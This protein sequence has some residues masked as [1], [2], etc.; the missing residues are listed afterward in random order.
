M[1]GDKI[2]EAEMHFEIPYIRLFFI[3]ELLEDTILP[4]T[5]AAALRDKGRKCWI[6][7]RMQGQTDRIPGRQQ[8]FLYT[9]LVWRERC[10]F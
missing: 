9:D 3:A 2:L 4:E 5:K 8:F 10:I 1:T 6:S 7:D